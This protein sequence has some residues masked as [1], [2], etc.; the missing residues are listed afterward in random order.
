MLMLLYASTHQLHKGR[1]KEM[2]EALHIGLLSHLTLF[3]FFFYK[4]P[5]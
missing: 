3:H 5:P 2:H 1:T 4:T